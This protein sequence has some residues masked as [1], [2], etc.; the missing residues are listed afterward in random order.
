MIRSGVYFVLMT[1]SLYNIP[2]ITRLVPKEIN[3]LRQSI[4]NTNYCISTA[5]YKICL[6]LR[7]EIASIAAICYTKIPDV[8]AIIDQSQSRFLERWV[9]SKGVPLLKDNDDTG[10]K[11]G[12]PNFPISAHL[13]VDYP[14][15]TMATMAT[16]TC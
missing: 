4:K 5:I 7:L 6:I 12:L 16:N 14:V 3:Q 13:R 15:Y 10:A 2:L 11:K 8:Y 9:M 1:G